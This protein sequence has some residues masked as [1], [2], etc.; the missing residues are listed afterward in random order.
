MLKYPILNNLSIRSFAFYLA[1]INNKLVSGEMKVPT[2]VAKA[3]FSDI[4]KLFL[5]DSK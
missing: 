2:H 4:I 1:Q 3:P 5:I